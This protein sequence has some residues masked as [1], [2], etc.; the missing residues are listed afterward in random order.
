MRP[1]SRSSIPGITVR[2]QRWTPSSGI[3]LPTRSVGAADSGVGDQEREWPELLLGLGDRTLD[4]AAVGDVELDC[5]PVDLAR[6]LVDL[7]A[8]PCGDRDAGSRS[9]EL[10]RDA[11]SDPAAA[12]GDEGDLA[13]ELAFGSHGPRIRDG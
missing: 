3:E 5:E 10:P 1:A 9:G 6:N 13:F 11:R 7:F 12:T 2:Q 8:S 4:R